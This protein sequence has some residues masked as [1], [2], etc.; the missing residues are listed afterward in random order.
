MEVYDWNTGTLYDDD[1]NVVGN[2]PSENIIGLDGTNR[3][4]TGF[5]DITASGENAIIVS[6]ETVEKFDPYAWGLP[7]LEL[8]GETHAMTKDNA[9]DLVYKYGDLNGT[10]SVKWQGSSSLQWEKKNYTIKFDQAFEAADGWGE[11]KKYCFKAN[12]IDACHAR[13]IVNAR[14]WGQIVKSRSSVPTELASL[15]NAGAV[16]GFPC[17]IMLNDEFHGLYTWNIPKDG[18][19]F[20]FDGTETQ[21]AIICADA[22]TEAT[23]FKAAATLDGDFEL[24]YVTDEDNAGWVKTSFNQLISACV[25]SDGTDLDTTIA[26]MMDWQSAIDLYIFVILICGGDLTDKNYILVKRDNNPWRFSAYDMDCTYGLHWTGAYWLP[27]KDNPT[28]AS[29][30]SLHRVMELIKL[31]KK[32]AL[33]ARYAELRETVMSEANLALVFGNFAALIPTPVYMQDIKTWP[34]I[35]NSAV[36]NVAQI[37]DYYRLRCALA[38]KWIEEL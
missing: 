34:T 23:R 13:N 12:F 38:D 28:F 24:E 19:M 15:V 36:N 11:Q 4:F 2:Y 21:G 18:W 33:K 26:A 3:L 27:V 35:P 37:R 30:A 20:G 1:G 17:I 5:G 22:H 14:L 7:V 16:D 9:V 8:T 29:F 32:D 31:Y 10:A 25:A 6:T